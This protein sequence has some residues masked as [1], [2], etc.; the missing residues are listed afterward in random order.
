MSAVSTRPDS[1][2]RREADKRTERLRRSF[3]FD[4]I[5]ALYALA[6]MIVGF[7]VLTD[8]FFSMSTAL[9]ILSE[10]AITVLVAIGLTIPLAAG[11]FDLSIHG[12]MGLAVVIVSRLMVDA[13]LPPI[14]AIALTLLTALPIGLVNGLLVTKA[15]MHPL[16]ATLG[17]GSI[18]IGSVFWISGNQNILGI[19]ADFRM[20][21]NT[22]LFGIP[23]LVY[24]IF[25]VALLLWYITSKTPV[26]RHL[27]ATGG[28]AEVA[29]LAGVRTNKIIVVSFILSSVIAMLAGIMVTA[30][31]GTGSP[32]VGPTYLLPAFAAAFLGATQFKRGRFNIWGTVLAVYL[33]A[34]GV[35]GLV[36]MGADFWVKDIF[37]G[38]ALV[39]AVALSSIQRSSAVSTDAG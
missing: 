30:R 16:I 26:G 29:R 31:L 9:S 20:I 7:S 25:L 34:T 8:E 17:M 12:S 14:V 32:T 28:S 13:G 11:V 39:L 21:A 5:G 18:L 15:K 35:K 37:N 36:L 3:A 6:I 22:Q 2:T 19:P 24:Y 33:L 10:Q 38:A 23:A 27:Y 1:D 4:R